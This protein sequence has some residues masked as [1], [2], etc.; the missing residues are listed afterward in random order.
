LPAPAPPDVAT[1]SPIIRLSESP[2]TAPTLQP[3]PPQLPPEEASEEVDSSPLGRSADGKSR[4]VRN[5]PRPR[6]NVTLG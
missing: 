2:P 3:T 5:L 6:Y 1:K 4:R